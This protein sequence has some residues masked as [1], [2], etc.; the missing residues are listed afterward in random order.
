MTQF[1]FRATPMPEICGGSV[2]VDPN[3]LETRPNLQEYAYCRLTQV[4]TI[5]VAEP[6]VCEAQ[7]TDGGVVPFW[8]KTYPRLMVRMIPH[9]EPLLGVTLNCQVSVPLEVTLLA[10]TPQSLI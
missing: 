5:A 9:G 4:P 1:S 10:V 6:T 7:V 3:R 2:V 8:G